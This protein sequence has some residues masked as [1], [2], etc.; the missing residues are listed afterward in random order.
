MLEKEKRK[1]GKKV[2][3][4]KKVK[5]K[6]KQKGRVKRTGFFPSMQEPRVSGDIMNQAALAVHF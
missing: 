1:K 6:K 2:K 4:V 3:K 5:K